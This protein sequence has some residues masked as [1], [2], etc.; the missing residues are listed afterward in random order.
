MQQVHTQLPNIFHSTRQ[1]GVK[2][3]KARNPLGRIT[4]TGQRFS[5]IMSASLI[6][7]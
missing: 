3:R 1:D 6:S 5:A 4:S 2:T 7:S